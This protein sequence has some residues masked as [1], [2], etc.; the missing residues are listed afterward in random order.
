MC[1]SIFGPGAAAWTST[2]A[3]VLAPHAV[4]TANAALAA[5]ANKHAT[6]RPNRAARTA[7]SIA[8]TAAGW[9]AAS[10]ARETLLRHPVAMNLPDD[11]RRQFHDRDRTLV[12]VL[13]VEDDEIGA[14]ILVHARRNAE[15]ITLALASVRILRGEAG[16]R[17]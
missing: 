8:S 5:N 14:T 1:R 2:C 6:A 16:L 17:E 15:Q 11:A 9:S 7:A 4:L 12:D 13:G 3:A 10:S